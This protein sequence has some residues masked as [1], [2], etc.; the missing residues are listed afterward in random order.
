MVV[1]TNTTFA[2]AVLLWSLT[3]RFFFFFFFSSFMSP[4]Y[5]FPPPRARTLPAVLYGGS[6]GVAPSHKCS[7]HASLQTKLT[8]RY[9][10]AA[11]KNDSSCIVSPSPAFLAAS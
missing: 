8:V 2:A 11:I 5:F 3:M 10:L 1:H 7:K 9:R 4:L 6:F